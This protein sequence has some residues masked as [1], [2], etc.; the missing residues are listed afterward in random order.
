MSGP[1][2]VIELGTAYPATRSGKVSLRGVL[3]DLRDLG[4]GGKGFLVSREYPVTDD[5]CELA[6]YATEALRELAEGIEKEYSK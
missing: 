2:L 4:K 1:L 6:R 5:P 3:Y